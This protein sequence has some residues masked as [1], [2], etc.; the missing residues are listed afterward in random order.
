M[1]TKTLR[2]E[3]KAAGLKIGVVTSLF[4]NDVTLVLQN[5]A[6]ERLKSL[7]VRDEDIT[8]VQVPGAFEIPLAVKA[9]LVNDAIDGVIALGAVIRGDTSHYDYVCNAVERGCS[10]LQLEFNK[11]VAFGVLTTENDDQALA[12]AGGSCGHKGVEAAE[13]VVEMC[14]LMKELQNTSQELDAPRQ[15]LYNI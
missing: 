7:G 6:L 11:P 5:G 1:K 12:R 2:G 15:T 4:N 9:L 14:N 10:A 8:A 3:L 13:V